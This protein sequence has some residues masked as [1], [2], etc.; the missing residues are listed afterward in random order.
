MA[1]AFS[2]LML[3]DLASAIWERQ[4]FA[5]TADSEILLQIQYRDPVENKGMSEPE[6]Q[7]F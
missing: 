4:L 1:I 2:L 6:I 3:I 7:R 5:K